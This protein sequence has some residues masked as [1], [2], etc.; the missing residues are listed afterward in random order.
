[1]EISPCTYYTDAADPS[2]GFHVTAVKVNEDTRILV[3]MQN[4]YK[5]LLLRFRE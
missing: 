3:G 4:E 1:M 5:G 2:A